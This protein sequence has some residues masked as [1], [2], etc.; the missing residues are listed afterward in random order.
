MNVLN[1]KIDYKITKTDKGTWRRYLYPTG[2]VFTEYKSHATF[3]GWPIIHYTIGICPETG[4]RIIARGVIAIGR[5]AVGGLAIGQAS[6]GLFAIGQACIG[7]IF[8]LGQA[9]GGTYA[10]GQ[11]ACALYFALGQLAIGYISIGQLAI[12]VYAF[13]QMGIGRYVWS[14]TVK[15][16]E[17]MSFFKAFFLKLR[18]IFPI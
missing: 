2:R 8:A 11:I 16:P 12:G 7:L 1:E 10:I 3:M 17:A 5:I 13:G 9:A 6:F 15:N 4:Q 18:N 14:I